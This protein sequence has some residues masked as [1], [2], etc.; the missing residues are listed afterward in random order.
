MNTDT[1]RQLLPILKQRSTI[2]GLL[3]LI[4]AIY[5]MFGGQLS[6]EQSAQISQVLLALVSVVAI[7]VQPKPAG[8]KYKPQDFKQGDQ[9]T[10]E[11]GAMFEMRGGKWVKLN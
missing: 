3:G 10:Q 2:A 5:A 6:P 1:L 11:D 9:V 4:T 7:V 8:G